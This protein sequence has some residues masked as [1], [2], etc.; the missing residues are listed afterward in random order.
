MSEIFR[1]IISVDT[2]YCHMDCSISNGIQVFR[3][4]L[5]QFG[6]SLP[7]VVEQWFAQLIAREE[8]QDVRKSDVQI[9]P[10]EVTEEREDDER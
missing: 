10:S 5:E 8:V 9:R 1:T 7:D 4:V 2:G 6:I 3:F